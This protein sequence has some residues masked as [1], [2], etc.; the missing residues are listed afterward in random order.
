MNTYLLCKDCVM[1]LVLLE[2]TCMGNFVASSYSY[3]QYHARETPVLS[4][5]GKWKERE[6][7]EIPS[8]FTDLHSI[9]AVIEM[10][11]S[12]SAFLTS[13]CFVSVW[14]VALRL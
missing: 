1:I 13:L 2:A 3:L 8:S 5:V 9:G 12:H 14:A 6:R 4:T 11:L 7:L 10:I